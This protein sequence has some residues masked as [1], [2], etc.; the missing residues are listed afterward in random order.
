MFARM[1][2]D[3]RT[4][5]AKDPAA[6]ST[7]EVLTCY[8]GLH[9]IWFHRVA[10]LMWRKRL[11]LLARMLSHLGRFLTGVEI[12]PG[13]TVGRRF[14]I[15]HGIGVV[16]GETADIADD[17][18]MY[19]GVV[20]GGTSLQK[21]KRHPTLGAGSVMG[22]GAILLGPITVGEGARVGA[23]SVVLHD[24]APHSV[25]VGVPARASLDVKSDQIRELE[26][27]NL[28]DPVANAIK[29]MLAE[30]ASIR[31]RMKKLEHLEGALDEMDRKMEEKHGEIMKMFAEKNDEEFKGGGGI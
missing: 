5:F 22:A 3:L 27:G 25:V 31:E 16:I 30:N 4:V 26:H 11:K 24:V 18:L 6:R 1:A 7:L 9:A 12:H 17:V 21:G 13:A 14:F 2:E 15:D 29:F 28:P 20:L 23:G 10:N 19:Q 8:P